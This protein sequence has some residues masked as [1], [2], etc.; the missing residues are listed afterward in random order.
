M[1]DTVRVPFM[2]TCDLSPD[3][4]VKVADG[5]VVLWSEVLRRLAASPQ[6]EGSSADELAQ[7]IDI[8]RRAA[9]VPVPDDDAD[10]DIEK[11]RRGAASWRAIATNVVAAY[12]ARVAEGVN[13]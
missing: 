11:A 3:A 4:L 1:T 7:Q 10:F 13:P 6:G 5:E 12:D 2:P 8:L 9:A